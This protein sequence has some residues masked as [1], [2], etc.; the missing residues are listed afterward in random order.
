[1]V[2]FLSL[3]PF[4][5]GSVKN[6]YVSSLAKQVMEE[7]W[8][9]EMSSQ[10]TLRS[11]EG[12]RGRQAPGR[13]R[14]SL[15]VM[16]GLADMLLHQKDCTDETSWTQEIAP[17]S[18]SKDR[19]DMGHQVVKHI[20]MCNCWKYSLSELP[21]NVHLFL[22]L[23]GASCHLCAWN[24][25]S[26]HAFWWR[27]FLLQ[28]GI[29][30]R[31]LHCFPPLQKSKINCSECWVPITQSTVKSLC[32]TFH[33]VPEAIPKERLGWHGLQSP[34]PRG[35]MGATP[36]AHWVPEP[37]G[38]Y[39]QKM[40]A[41]SSTELF[42]SWNRTKAKPWTSPPFLI[43]P[44]LHCL[45]NVWACETLG[46]WNHSWLQLAAFSALDFFFFFLILKLISWGGK[47]SLFLPAKFIWMHKEILLFEKHLSAFTNLDHSALV[48]MAM[49][50]SGNLWSMEGK[51]NTSC[52]IKVIL[53]ASVLCRGWHA[54]YNEV[55]SIALFNNGKGI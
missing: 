28:M 10:K 6:S 33:R 50:T 3:T 44:P 27:D 15:S 35:G 47:P 36:P 23:F 25:K 13:K 18:S 14:K 43:P 37:L 29:L 51:P 17:N 4:A 19:S 7:K 55:T 53:W 16:W 24:F 38:G 52:K 41:A 2:V 49:D 46:K 40:K 20:R 1:M 48:A 9:E 22:S 26:L 30:P 21:S 8:R 45:H 34:Q 32:H 42:W 11:E 31:K 5:P 54:S 39:G 12:W